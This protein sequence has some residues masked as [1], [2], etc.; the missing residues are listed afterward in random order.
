MFETEA[1]YEPASELLKKKI[2]AEKFAVTQENINQEKW[3]IK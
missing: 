3:K 1:D 2:K